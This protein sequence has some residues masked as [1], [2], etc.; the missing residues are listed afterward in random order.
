MNEKSL[1]APQ[2]GNQLP[3][4]VINLARSPERRQ[5]MVRQLDAQ[6]LAHEFFEGVDGAM[7]SSEEIDSVYSEAATFDRLGRSMPPNEMACSWSHL[8]VYQKMVDE[9]IAEAL[10]LED[11]ID[12]SGDLSLVLSSRS[13]WLPSDWRVVNFAHDMS[14]P[15]LLYPIAVTGL[16]HLQVCRFERVVGRT[17]AYLIR[18][19]GAESL[20]RH[21]FPIRMPPDDLVGN[22]EFVGVHVYG[23]VPHVAMWD[24]N[25]QSTIWTQMTRDQFSAKSRGGA[26]GIVKRLRRR[27][28]KMFE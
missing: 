17:G 27:I 8:K 13:E 3:I 22:S 6:L 4:F 20:L 19:E 9:H 10:I 1:L 25:F 21:A 11:D 2:T 26:S 23:L 5:K 12:L 14:Q 28:R 7:L 16:T 24:D 15:I 18:L